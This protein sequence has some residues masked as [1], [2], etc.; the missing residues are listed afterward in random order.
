M[1][2]NVS[3]WRRFF[4][5]LQILLEFLEILFFCS[6]S[7]EHSFKFSEI[8]WKH[9]IQNPAEHFSIPHFQ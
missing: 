1:V 9:I 5:S 3:I 6:E 8:L 2:A 4:H 7:E